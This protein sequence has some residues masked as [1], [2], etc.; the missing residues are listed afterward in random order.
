MSSLDRD[1]GLPPYP[2]FICVSVVVCRAMCV[3]MSATCGV[4]W[5]VICCVIVRV[6]MNGGRG[7]EVKTRA[8]GK[9]EQTFDSLCDQCP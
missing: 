3:V 2:P 9:E 8:Q 6:V 5:W 4:V 7:G 1:P